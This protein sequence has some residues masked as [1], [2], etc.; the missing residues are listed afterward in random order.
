MPKVRPIPLVRPKQV[1]HTCRHCNLGF[2]SFR[3]GDWHLAI[4]EAYLKSEHS[5]SDSCKAEQF[6]VG[7]EY[8]PFKKQDVTHNWEVQPGATMADMEKPSSECK[9]LLSRNR[10]RKCSILVKLNLV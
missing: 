3:L 1:W 8:D 4:C 2:S 6:L 5:T 7:R 10:L 9:W